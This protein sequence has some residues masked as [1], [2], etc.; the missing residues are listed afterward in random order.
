MDI[1]E[2]SEGILDIHPINVTG[3]KAL[4]LPSNAKTRRISSPP[5][6][7]SPK[8]S[9]EKIQPPL[10]E[11]TVV[12]PS[13]SPALKN[14]RK[15]QLLCDPSFPSSDNRDPGFRTIDTCYYPQSRPKTGSTVHF[16]ELPIVQSLRSIQF[17][18]FGQLTPQPDSYGSGSKLSLSRPKSGVSPSP[19][20]NEGTK[21]PHEE[22]GDNYKISGKPESKNI[23]LEEIILNPSYN[24]STHITPRIPIKTSNANSTATK[25]PKFLLQLPQQQDGIFYDRKEYSISSR[26]GTTTNA[27]RIQTNSKIGA[28]LHGQASESNR[29]RRISVSNFSPY[30]SE[31]ENAELMRIAQEAERFWSPNSQNRKKRLAA[32]EAEAQLLTIEM[33]KR[34]LNLPPTKTLYTVAKSLNTVPKSTSSSNLHSPRKKPPVIDEGAIRSMRVNAYGTYTGTWVSEWKEAQKTRRN[35]PFSIEASI[36]EGSTSRSGIRSSIQ[37]TAKDKEEPPTMFFSS[38]QVLIPRT[39][40]RHKAR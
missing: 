28:K 15:K 14:A 36:L 30:S 16:S 27:L 2:N 18:Q 39:Y 38:K 34:E 9:E 6:S 4:I 33:I 22:Y 3:T 31:Q 19:Y 24:S 29:P 20:L 7:S 1:P 12:R 17:D 21:L 37:S 11:S 40:L 26:P 13:T 10:Q 23:K 25:T 32:K 5:K 8:E 35:I